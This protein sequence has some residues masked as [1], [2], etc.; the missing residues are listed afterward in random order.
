MTDSQRTANAVLVMHK[1]K[2]FGFLTTNPN[3]FWK[4]SRFFNDTS[5]LQFYYYF[6]VEVCCYC[7]AKGTL[8]LIYIII[9]NPFFFIVKLK[10]TFLDDS[11]QINKI[12]TKQKKFYLYS[13][14]N[15]C[16]LQTTNDIHLS[17]LVQG[18]LQGL[19]RC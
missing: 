10:H 13:G 16:F 14:L 9:D 17:N 3:E 7:T 15:G 4:S 5:I 6:P 2:Y 8:S 18:Y 11:I 1:K 19:A 12:I